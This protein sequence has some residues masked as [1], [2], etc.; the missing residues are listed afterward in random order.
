MDKQ[1]SD[2]DRGDEDDRE[3]AGEASDSESDDEEN[4]LDAKNHGLVTASQTNIIGNA[5]EMV[6][7][8]TPLGFMSPTGGAFK[9]GERDT[10]V[11]TRSMKKS[12]A[13]AKSQDL[14]KQLE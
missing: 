5:H 1:T 7:G 3:E 11:Q 13:S 14:Q 12:A 9:S 10:I 2:E 4:Y 8:H 6:D